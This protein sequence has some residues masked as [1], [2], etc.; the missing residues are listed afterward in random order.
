MKGAGKDK[1]KNITVPFNQFYSLEIP[2]EFEPILVSGT[3]SQIEKL[4]K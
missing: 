3:K 1:R 4:K 2:L